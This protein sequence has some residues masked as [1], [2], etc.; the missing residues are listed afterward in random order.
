MKNAMISEKIKEQNISEM[1]ICPD[2][3]GKT[4]NI[5][6]TNG[7]NENCIYC[8]PAACGHH[9]K[10]RMI[11][12]NFFY[13]VTK[14]ARD[15][16]IT[17][18]GLYTQGEPLVNPKVYEYVSYLK[19]IGFPYVYISTNGIL[20]T[21][22]NL[23]RLVNAGVDSIKF[24]V[25]GATKEGFQR[26]HGVD[27]FE[28]VR[29]NIEYAYQYRT[30]NK[31]SYRLFM[32]SIITRYN[33]EEK[34]LIRKTFSPYVD[35][36]VFSN[37]KNGVFEIEGMDELLMVKDAEKDVIEEA[38]IGRKIPCNQLFNRIVID[39]DGY[40]HVCCD[41]IDVFT[42]VIDVKNI[43]LKDAVYSKEMKRIRKMHLEHCIEHT[44]CNRCAYGHV[45][46]IKSFDAL[47]RD[48]MVSVEPVKR[49]AEILKR[50]S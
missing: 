10:V 29:Q 2:F 32:F 7:C 5:E 11:D 16:G 38:G 8:Y 19:T 12:E 17:N 47:D 33:C 28:S 34:E 36:L 21:P 50:F 23:E 15:L 30:E 18:V 27:A 22:K 14:E 44:I 25:S 39:Q 1:S 4:L 9:K 37:V 48:E 49:K 3:T 13:R 46:G 40:L 43:S 41:T 42:R 35:E 6:I 45:E 31:L 20:C 24:S 26:H